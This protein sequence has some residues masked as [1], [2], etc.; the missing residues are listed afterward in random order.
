MGKA[1]LLGAAI[2]IAGCSVAAALRAE[3]TSDMRLIDFVGQA[4]AFEHRG[5]VLL[6]RVGERVPG[7]GARVQHVGTR[8]VLLEYEA[9]APSPAATIVLTRG[10]LLRSPIRPETDAA[11]QLAPLLTA[12]G[13]P[14]VTAPAAATGER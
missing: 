3:T 5:R 1:K 14:A 11:Q 12:I 6:V 8:R 4:A 13:R 2:L 9:S 10:S 7:T